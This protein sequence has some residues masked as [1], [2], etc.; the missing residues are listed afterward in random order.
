MH[1]HL[2]HHT[3]GGCLLVDTVETRPGMPQKI[4]LPCDDD[5]E[6]P[7]GAERRFLSTQE[8]HFKMPELMTDEWTPPIGVTE[9]SR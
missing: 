5:Y 8:R 7:C 6:C 2:Y 4:S 1:E 9:I 3:G